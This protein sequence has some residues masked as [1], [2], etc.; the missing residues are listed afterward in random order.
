MLFNNENIHICNILLYNWTFFQKIST[1]NTIQ[2]QIWG[3]ETAYHIV[4]IKRPGLEFLQKSLLNV[5]YDRKNVGLNILSY[6][7][8][9]R[10]MRVSRWQVLRQ[11]SLN[12]YS[13]LKFLNQTNSY[14]RGHVLKILFSKNYYKCF[15]HPIFSSFGILVTLVAWFSFLFFPSCPSCL[16]K[17][18]QRL[19][20][21]FVFS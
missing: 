8:Y 16:A 21:I 18:K 7:T 6:R 1:K 3:S 2:S 11:V 4:S 17:C 19:C 5:P 20:N 10:V 15:V 14:A 13:N 12:Q 9:N